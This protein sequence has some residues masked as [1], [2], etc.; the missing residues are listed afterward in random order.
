LKENSNIEIQKNVLIN[1]N[2]KNLEILKKIKEIS[3]STCPTCSRPISNDDYIE[4]E[5]NLL[6]VNKTKSK[7]ISKIEE[8]IEKIKLENLQIEEKIRSN[9]IKIQ[10]FDL[11]SLLK[12]KEE[13]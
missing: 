1:E 6:L 5:K 4:I 13:L 11:L 7:E 8:K 12:K 9:T 10:E 3:N 2:N